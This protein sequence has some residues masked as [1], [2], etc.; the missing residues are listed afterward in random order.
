[1]VEVL[2]ELLREKLHSWCTCSM[3]VKMGH[4][5]LK[6]RNVSWEVQTFFSHV[7]LNICSLA[8]FASSLLNILPSTFRVELVAL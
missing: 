4:V 8:G 5:L 3:I 7:K 1:M 6:V 2:E